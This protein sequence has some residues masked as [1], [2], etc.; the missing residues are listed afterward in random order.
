MKT[1]EEILIM[2][3]QTSKQMHKLPEIGEVLPGLS[4]TVTL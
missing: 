3:K 2:R 4:N 1:E